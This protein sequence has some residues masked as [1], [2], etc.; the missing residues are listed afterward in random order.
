M[1]KNTKK[2]RSEAAR[3]AVRTTKARNEFFDR[4]PEAYEVAKLAAAGLTSEDIAWETHMSVASVAAYRANLSRG[5]YLPFDDGTGH[6]T[7]RM[8][9]LRR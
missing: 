1:K 3:Q 4:N 8:A 5:S 6:G 2:T 9:W 7:A